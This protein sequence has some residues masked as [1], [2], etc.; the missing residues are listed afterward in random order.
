MTKT[1]QSLIAQLRDIARA[2]C[3]DVW[4][5]ALNTA[6][7]STKLELR[8]PDRVY[9]PPTLRLAPNPP[10]P[11][12]VLGL[13]SAPTSTSV[14]PTTILAAKPTTET[15]Q[16]QPPP[17]IVVDVESKDVVEEEEEGEGKR[18]RKR[19]RKRGVRMT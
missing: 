8:A 12:N 7:V 17:T 4:G 2:F 18:A 6:G 15:K 11:S 3:L 1:A 5:E 10:Q 14:Q 16:D 19:E 9:Y 13:A